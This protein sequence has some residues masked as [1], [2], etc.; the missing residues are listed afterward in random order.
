M[1]PNGL[2]GKIYGF[3]YDREDGAQEQDFERVRG[4]QC[5][6]VCSILS[7]LHAETRNSGQTADVCVQPCDTHFGLP[8]T[9]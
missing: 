9:A 8:C 6:T 3:K 4:V 1:M 2:H 7:A 5:E